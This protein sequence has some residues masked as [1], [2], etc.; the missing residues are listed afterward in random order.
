M[1]R[2]LKRYLEFCRTPGGIFVNIASVFGVIFLLAIPPLQTPDEAVHFLRAYDVSQGGFFPKNVDGVTGSY[3]P[4]SLS[5]MMTT[6]SGDSQI[7]FHPDN[8]YRLGFTKDALRIGLNPQDKQLYDIKAASTY[9]P[10]GYAPQAAGILIGRIFNA[11]PILLLFMA[12]LAILAAWV[13]L[14]YL[15]IKLIPFKKWGLAAIL[16]FPMFIAQS[17]AMGVDAISI[18]SGL[19]FVCG[20]LR[21]LHD[22]RISKKMSVLIL[23][24]A[25]LMVLSKQI[26]VVLLPLALLIPKPTIKFK[27][28]KSWVFK[29]IIILVPIFVLASWSLLASSVLATEASTDVGDSPN[30]MGQVMFILDH[31]MQ[32]FRVLFNTYFFDWGDSV[33]E[34]FIGVFGWIDTPL[35][36]MAIVL[37]YVALTFILFV[38]YR[39]RAVLVTNNT[40]IMAGIL[41]IAYFFAVCAALY[42]TYTPI[43]F[44]IIVGIQGRYLLPALFLLIPTFYAFAYTSKK[45]Y[46][47]IAFASVVALLVVSVV[48]IIFRYYINYTY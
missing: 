31:P 22:K 5:K 6:V 47:T 35:P 20:V 29:L 41:A 13:G 16:L 1:K 23:G 7:Q 19:L 18:S 44:N 32:P 30:I 17:V 39:E 28:L 38:S 4:S 2:L 26:M 10:T 25:I 37:G 46:I 14:G 43:G 15:A 21:V 8:K 34:S 33:I 42:V 11:P 36:L 24:A 3:L 12:R 27:H 45:R 9:A 48:T 40:R